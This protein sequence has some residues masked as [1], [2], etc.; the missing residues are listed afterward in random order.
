MR[1]SAGCFPP[2]GPEVMDIALTGG[3][4]LEALQSRL[5]AVAAVH[6]RRVGR[7]RFAVATFALPTG[8]GRGLIEGDCQLGAGR[9]RLSWRPRG[10]AAAVQASSSRVWQGSGLDDRFERGG[11]RQKG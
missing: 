6:V 11:K 4:A 5:A 2:E 1:S 3:R 8:G 7:P 9:G 10:A